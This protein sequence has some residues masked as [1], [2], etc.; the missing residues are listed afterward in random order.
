MFTPLSAFSS[1]W[2]R[3]FSRFP[4]FFLSLLWRYPRG[5]LFVES[6]GSRC[7]SLPFSQEKFISASL[8]FLPLRK[9][10]V[11]WII[12]SLLS[13]P[14]SLSP[15][16]Y[17]PPL[18]HKK[19]PVASVFRSSRRARLS[20]LGFTPTPNR[21]QHHTSS[22]VIATTHKSLGQGGAFPFHTCT[23]LSLSL[24]RTL[25]H[26]FSALVHPVFFFCHRVLVSMR[27]VHSAFGGRKSKNTT[28]TYP[29]AVQSLSSLRRVCSSDP[30]CPSFTAHPP[31]H[32]GFF[33]PK[34]SPLFLSSPVCSPYWT[35]AL[36]VDL[37][38]ET[39]SSNVFFPPPKSRTK[40]IEEDHLAIGGRLPGSP[41]FTARVQPHSVNSMLLLCGSPPSDFFAL[42]TSIA[43]GS[44][45]W[46]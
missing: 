41:V 16:H 23:S 20:R 18:T 35:T 24:S 7:R 4:L 22:Y 19:L 37:F 25:F 12:A 1:W 5:P 29:E 43:C 8:P 32:D 13:S 34:F 28:R 36:F 26:I 17:N 10:K 2:P 38:F 21:P 46:Q 45:G 6:L 40:S 39:V 33:P 9:K 14:I 11:K 44:R 30:S 42:R 3:I 15:P 27:T 31:L